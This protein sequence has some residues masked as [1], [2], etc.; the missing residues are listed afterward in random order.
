MAKIDTQNTYECHECGLVQ[1]SM[2][3]SNEENEMVVHCSVC[4]GFIQVYERQMYRTNLPKRV[5]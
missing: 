1:G 4:G 5:T 2:S 3:W